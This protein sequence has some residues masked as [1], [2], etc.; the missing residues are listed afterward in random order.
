MRLEQF[1]IEFCTD[2]KV[3][4]AVDDR[5]KMLACVAI[6]GELPSERCSKIARLMGKLIAECQ[7]A[8]V[9]VVEATDVS[10]GIKGMS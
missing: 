3:C 1:I 8:D 9:F 5:G 4:Q 7:N 2:H 10:N 6:C